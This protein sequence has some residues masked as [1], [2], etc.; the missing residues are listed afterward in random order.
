MLELE[1]SCAF[2]MDVCP[3]CAEVNGA[4]AAKISKGHIILVV[5]IHYG[6]PVSALCIPFLRYDEVA[7]LVHWDKRQSHA[8]FLVDDDELLASVSWCE[9]NE[10]G[11]FGKDHAL[12]G[13]FGAMDDLEGLGAMQAASLEVKTR[14]MQVEGGE[15]VLTEPAILVVAWKDW[16]RLAAEDA[17]VFS[18]E[19]EHGAGEERPRE[20]KEENCT[21]LGF[22]RH[23]VRW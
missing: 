7:F 23:C 3:L 8:F 1:L 20:S 11:V 6:Q 9:I 10:V 17:L 18:G 19:D 4:L 21:S 14:V 15:G 13:V 2:K 22:T 16:R 12:I 5:G